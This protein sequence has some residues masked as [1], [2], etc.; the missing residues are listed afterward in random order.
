MEKAEEKKDATTDDVDEAKQTTLSATQQL[1]PNF[2]LQF[3]DVRAEN[4]LFHP[5]TG[6]CIFGVDEEGSLTASLD[7]NKSMWSRPTLYYETVKEMRDEITAQ[8]VARTKAY[9]S[10]FAP[11]RSICT[12]EA[13]LPIIQ[14]FFRRIISLLRYRNKIFVTYVKNY[15]SASY[16]FYFTNLETDASQWHRPVGLGQSA[17]NGE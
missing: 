12:E 2:Q 4:Y 8:R 13:A 11:P 3:D 7:R 16:L 15:D 17:E 14:N 1:L 5:Y 10:T 9:K 6:E